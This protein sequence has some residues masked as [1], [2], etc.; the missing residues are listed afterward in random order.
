VSDGPASGMA[1]DRPASGQIGACLALPHFWLT[2]Y[3]QVDKLGSWYKFVNF[4]AK[5]GTSNGRSVLK[6]ASAF[7]LPFSE[8]VT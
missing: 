3:S 1:C 2:G 6:K 8:T 5:R 7:F 4:G